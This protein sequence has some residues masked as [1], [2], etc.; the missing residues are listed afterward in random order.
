MTKPK[1]KHAPKNFLRYLLDKYI[2]FQRDFFI[3][4]TLSVEECV[5]SMLALS[6]EEREDEF[7]ARRITPYVTTAT[8]STGVVYFIVIAEQQIRSSYVQSANA[9]GSIESDE[10][11]TTRITGKVLMSG[12]AFWGMIG[13]GGLL[14]LIFIMANSI[15]D[16]ATSQWSTVSILILFGAFMIYS[17]TQMYRDR[18]YLVQQIQ[19]AIQNAEREVHLSKAKNE[20]IIPQ[21]SVDKY[22]SHH[23]KE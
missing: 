23:A 6:Q 12:L 16:M 21:A 9:E 5:K 3:E 4:T 22:Q 11:R 18:N 14:L 7:N 2:L 20:D 1:Q 15:I 19:H 8:E 10:E 13:L 17:W